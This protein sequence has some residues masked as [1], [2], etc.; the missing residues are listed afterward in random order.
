MPVTNDK[1]NQEN[2]HP[3]KQQKAFKICVDKVYADGFA[4]SE[5]AQQKQKK[6]MHKAVSECVKQ[7]VKSKKHGKKARALQPMPNG[8]STRALRGM[9]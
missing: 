9:R 1:E 3:L 8:S 2:Q 6:A 5:S 4:D 7:S